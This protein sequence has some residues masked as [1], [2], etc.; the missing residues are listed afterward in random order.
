MIKTRG[1]ETNNEPLCETSEPGERILSRDEV[2]STTLAIGRRIL[3]IFGYQDIANIVFR[4]RSRRSEID[5]V[6]SGEAMPSV[7]LLLAIRKVTGVSLD[8][9]MTG[10]GQK[11]IPE[12]A[13]AFVADLKPTAIIRRKRPA[14]QLV[15][16]VGQ[17]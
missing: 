2:L 10:E 7:E 5:A 14:I 4:L 15:H 3:E 16:V 9:L 1:T 6:V 17:K 12:P 11:F 8:W 13:P